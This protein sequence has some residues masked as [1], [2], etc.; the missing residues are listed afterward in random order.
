MS[1]CKSSIED[2]SN[3]EAVSGFLAPETPCIYRETKYCGKKFELF[4][5]T[6]LSNRPAWEIISLRKMT[7]W[8]IEKKYHES[9]LDFIEVTLPIL[10]I[11]VPAMLLGDWKKK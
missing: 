9:I 5:Y 2:A 10:V 6:P 4:D 7:E 3:G 8:N 11:L 1:T